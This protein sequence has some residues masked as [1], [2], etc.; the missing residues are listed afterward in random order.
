MSK[1]THKGNCQGCGRLQ[2]VDNLSKMIA[3]H[4]YKVSGYGFFNG[5]CLGSNRLTMQME[6]V[7]T[8]KVCIMMKEQ[9]DRLMI[10]YEKLSNGVDLNIL[11]PQVFIKTERRI[12]LNG[13]KVSVDVYAT[14]KEADEMQRA[15]QVSYE[16]NIALSRSA[17]LK[18]TIKYLSELSERVFMTDLKPVKKCDVVLDAV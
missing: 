14:Y 15:R 11:V 9:S 5:M 18:Q 1:H 4:G 6:I 12:D 13:K 16:M 7:Y 17:S 3:K 2:A 10:R 8:K